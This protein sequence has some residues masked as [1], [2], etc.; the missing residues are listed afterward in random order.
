M[1]VSYAAPSGYYS[2]ADVAVVRG[3]T[4]QAAF[5][6]LTRNA[7]DH[8]IR[9]GRFGVISKVVYRRLALAQHIEDKFA[10]TDA[11]LDEVQDGVE[12]AHRRIDDLVRKVAELAARR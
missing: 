11:I 12:D 3:T 8:F 9:N 1:N 10:K 7:K 6:W 5:N 2:V 4:R